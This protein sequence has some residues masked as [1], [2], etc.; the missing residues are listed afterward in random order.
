MD[1]SQQVIRRISETHYC[2]YEGQYSQ[3]SDSA[4]RYGTALEAE[5]Q[6]QLGRLIDQHDETI[7]SKY[8]Y[9]QHG[10]QFSH[11]YPLKSPYHGWHKISWE[12]LRKEWESLLKKKGFKDS[13]VVSTGNGFLMAHLFDPPRGDKPDRTNFFDI[14]LIIL[15]LIHI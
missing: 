10:P 8:E 13:K 11:T 1:R 15:S 9:E 5:I 2:L 12:K 3:W 4:D 7:R 14:V 6:K